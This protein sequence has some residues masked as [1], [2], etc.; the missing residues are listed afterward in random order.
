MGWGGESTEEAIKQ[1]GRGEEMKNN[2]NIKQWGNLKAMGKIQSR[3]ANH[4]RVTRVRK[5]VDKS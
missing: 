2:R 5:K 4:P 1:W 3:N